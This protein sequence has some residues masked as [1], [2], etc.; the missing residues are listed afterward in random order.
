MDL[1]TLSRRDA[2]VLALATVAGRP[3]AAADNYPSRQVTI[4]APSAAGGPIDVYTR[5]M[6]D[7]LRKALHQTFFVKDEPGGG[8]TIGTNEV[9]KAVPD[10]YTLLVVSEAQTVSET[11]YANKPYQLLRDLTAVAPMMQTDLVLVVHPSVQAN[12]LQ[13]FLALARDRPGRFK[14]GSAGLGSSSHMAGELFKQITGVDIVHWPEKDSSDMRSSILSGQ[15]QILFDA[16]PSVAPIIR[17]GAL[18]ALATGGT[19]RSPTLPDVPTFPEAGVDYQTPVWVGLMAPKGTPQPI[20]DLLNRT[21]VGI[22]NRQDFKD[23][24]QRQGAI[25]TQMTRDE[26]TAFLQ[27]EV[28]KWAMVIQA[29]HIPLIEVGH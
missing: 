21:V 15:T 29:N 13:E 25:P 3:A 22:D 8:T 12:N 5:A 26:F 1:P 17:S 19:L 27:R 16:I 11:L 6:A 18:R 2:L 28:D 20:I 4:V 10:G 23:A 7:E 9:A 24:W 14:Y